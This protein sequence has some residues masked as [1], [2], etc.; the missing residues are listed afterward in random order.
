MQVSAGHSGEL[1]LTYCTNVHPGDTLKHARSLLPRFAPLVRSLQ[2]DPQTPVAW[3]LFLG[4]EAIHE[5][6]ADRSLGRDL[7]DRMQE[8]NTY[9]LTMNAFPMRGFHDSVVKEQVYRPDWH[10]PERYLHTVRTARVLASL[11]SRSSYQ[12]ISTLPGS[13]KGFGSADTTQIAHHIKLVAQELTRI[14]AETG[15]RIVLAVEPEPGCTFE[16]TDEWISFFET[17]LLNAART[18]GVGHDRVSE[19]DMRRHVGVCFDCCHQ[20]VE[21]EDVAA[22]LRRLV[23]SDITIAKIQLSTALRLEAPANSPDALRRLAAFDEPRYLHQ[24]GARGQDGEVTIFRD[25]GEYLPLAKQR[26]DSSCRIHFHVPI[27]E[28]EIGAGLLTTRPDLLQV[29]HLV[30]EKSITEHLEIETYSFDALPDTCNDQ[31]S[32]SE[33]IAREYHFVLSQLAQH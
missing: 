23:D 27:F 1:H 32:L 26:D 19:D 5:M 31:L 18:S 10:D 14:E 28:A 2:K 6:E 7:C 30:R 20:S 22:S 33:S 12:S 29:I 8:C 13:F 25:L 4:D 3:G 16:T 24:V 17:D 21:F 15:R 11:P 9:A